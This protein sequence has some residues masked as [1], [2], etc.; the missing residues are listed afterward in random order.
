MHIIYLD[1]LMHLIKYINLSSDQ[2]SWDGRP[3]TEAGQFRPT[4]SGSD[5]LYKVIPN[6]S[7]FLNLLKV[8]VIL[9]NTR[10][11]IDNLYNFGWQVHLIRPG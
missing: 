6:K 11:F 1:S 9:A 2:T 10:L 4:I 7:G 8:I 3:Q 5:C